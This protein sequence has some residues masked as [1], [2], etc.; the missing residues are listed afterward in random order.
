MKQGRRLMIFHYFAQLVISENCIN[1]CMLH[2]T[3]KFKN[4][5]ME[6]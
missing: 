4:Q 6:N 1:T 5:L 3:T 2:M